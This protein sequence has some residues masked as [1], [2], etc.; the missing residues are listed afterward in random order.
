[1]SEFPEKAGSLLWLKMINDLVPYNRWDDFKKWIPSI[2]ILPICI[3]LVLNRGNY[4][5]IDNADLVIHEAGHFFFKF[6][7]KFIYTAGGTL[8]QIILP[9]IIVFYFLR[10]MYRLGVQISL[11]WLGQNLINI[12]VYAADAQARKLPLLGGS[13]VYHD[14]HYMLG[15]I[16]L[17]DYSSEVGYFFVGIAVLVFILVLTMPLIITD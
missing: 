2:I 13:S 3:Y 12:S 5:L 11:L 16:G 8:M 9:S 14:W 15:E 7:G 6:F 17:L 10:N 4:G 1:M